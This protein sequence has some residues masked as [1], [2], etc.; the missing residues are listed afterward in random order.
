[1]VAP[2]DD[3]TLNAVLAA[4]RVIGRT[5][6]A[7]IA[8]RGET[9]GSGVFIRWRER[10][11]VATAAHVL[12]DIKDWDSVLVGSVAWIGP[13]PRAL[14]GNS[15]GIE[16]S[17]DVGVME[18]HPRFVPW[19]D[20]DWVTADL[21]DDSGLVV[22]TPLAVLG[23]PSD[24]AVPPSPGS[25]GK[26]TPTISFGNATNTPARGELIETPLAPDSDLWIDFSFRESK[27]PRTGAGLRS[28]GLRGVS[29][30]GVFALARNS[31]PVVAGLPDVRLVGIE[32]AQYQS[33]GKLR[34]ARVEVVKAVLEE[35]ARRFPSPPTG[36]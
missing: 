14:R 6:A 30:G 13:Y 3:G 8:D 19:L 28:N 31:A 27:D 34:A 18:L 7:L 26:V 9:Q 32:W 35:F 1:M 20:V 2:L 10:Y 12:R 29:G 17:Y 4:Q 25:L 21:M 33:D 22:G 36:F 23:F 11:F 16:G 5:T 24:L 15:F